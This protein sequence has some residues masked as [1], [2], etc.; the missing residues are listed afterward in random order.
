MGLRDRHLYHDKKIF[1]ITTTCYRWLTLLSIGD[2]FKIISQSLEFCC[3]KYEASILGYVIMPNHLHMI[4]HFGEG[5]KRID[6]MRDFKKFTSVEIRKQ[7]EIQNPELLESLRCYKKD[8]VFKVWQNRFDEVYLEGR[9]LLETKLD[10]I[11]NNPLQEK[12]ALV[13][14]PEDYRHS[15]ASFYEIGTNYMI[16]VKHYLD[17]I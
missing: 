6:F 10:Y 15:S 7:V 16:D 5:M 3:C 8:Q 17:F 1:F 13:K 4:I 12:W 14:R 2:G 9:K 11:H